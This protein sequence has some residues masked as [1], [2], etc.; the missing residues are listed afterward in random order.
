MKTNKYLL[1]PI[2]LLLTSCYIYKPYSEKEIVET[3]KKNNTSP[4]EQKSIRTE[5]SSDVAAQKTKEQQGTPQISLEDTEP[6]KVLE[7]DQQPSKSDE[8]S[9]MGFSRSDGSSDDKSKRNTNKGIVKAE[10][11]KSTE[12]GIKSKLLPNKYYKITAL[13][14]QYKI[15]VDKWEGDTLVSHKIRKP[16][17]VYRHHMNDIQEESILERRFSKPFSDLFT[18]GAYASGAAIVLLLIL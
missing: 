6:Q 14:H 12:A 4:A 16:G 10:D 7:K 11:T 5:R 17:K 1:F 13:D 8:K 2:I 9:N 18:I 15:Q 3:I